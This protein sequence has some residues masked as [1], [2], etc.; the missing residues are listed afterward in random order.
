[1]RESQSVI[2][3]EGGLAKV[4]ERVAKVAPSAASV[5]ILGETGS[6]KEVIARAIH[7]QSPR[8]AGPFIRVNCGALPPELLDSEL[9]GHVKGSFTGAIGSRKGWFGRADRGTLFLDEIGELPLA[10]QVRLLRVLQDGL[11][12]PVGSEDETAVDVRVVAATHRDLPVMVQDG[13]FREDLWYRLAV[14]PIIIPPLHE[15]PEDM[16]ELAEYFIRRSAERLGVRTPGLDAN[17]LKRLQRYRWPGNVRELSAVLERAVILGQGATLELA[18][19]LGTGTTL[20]LR[21]TDA[22][23]AESD[24]VAGDEF[25]TLDAVVIAHIG[26]ALEQASGRVSGSGG[27]AR[28]LGLNPNTLRSKMRKYGIPAIQ[29]H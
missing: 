26:R 29:R 22:A 11:L 2:G 25:P 17:D 14:F 13:H 6:G 19:A 1:M 18:P 23:M 3:V 9:F 10:G 20:V 16:R 4:M 7:E 24:D 5:L 15:R 27:A 8:S 21:A 12:R 28:L